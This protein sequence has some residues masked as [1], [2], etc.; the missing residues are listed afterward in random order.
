MKPFGFDSCAEFS[1]IKRIAA[2]AG[3]KKNNT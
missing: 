2:S 3:E 1:D